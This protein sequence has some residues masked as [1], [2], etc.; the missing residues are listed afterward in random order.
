MRDDQVKP[1]PRVLLFAAFFLTSSAAA[2]TAV[3]ERYEYDALG[4]LIKVVQDDGMGVEF[5]YDAAGNRVEVV[6]GFPKLDSNLRNGVVVVPLNG[7]TTIV[8]E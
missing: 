6:A 8:I 3:D 2:Q 5:E 4:R 1:L 7:F